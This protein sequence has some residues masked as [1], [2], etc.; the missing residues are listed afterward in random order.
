MYEKIEADYSYTENRELSWL[1]FNL[2]VLEEANCETTPAFERLKFISIFTSNL[3]EFYMVRVGSLYDLATADDDEPDNKSGLTCKEQLEA[4]YEKSVKLYEKKDKAYNQVA[5]ALAQHHICRPSFDELTLSEKKYIDKYFK[6]SILPLL[7]PQVVDNMHPFPHLVNKQPYVAAVLR[8]GKNKCYGLIPVFPAL[9][10]VIVLPE[11]ELRFMLME[12]VI[13]HYAET[14]FEL[15]DVLE[16]TVVCVTRNADIDTDEGLYDADLDFRQHMKTILKKRARLAPVRLETAAPLSEGFRGF[17]C[18][19]LSLR[20]VQVFVSRSPLNM[21]Y[22]FSLED[23]L[24]SS[25][26]QLLLNTPFQPQDSPDVHLRQSLIRQALKKDIL[27]SYPFESMKPFLNLIREAASDPAVLSIKITL[28]RISRESKLAEYLIEAAENGKEITVL[29]ELRARFDEQNNIEWAQRLEEAGC[30]VIYG[31]DGYKVHSKICLIMRKDRSR[32]QYITQIGTGNYNEKT[33]RLYTDLSL[34]TADPAICEDAVNFFKN[35]ALSNLEGSYDKLWVAPYSLKSNVIR[36]IDQEIEKAKQGRKARILMKMNSLTDRDVIDKLAE[37]SQNGVPVKLVIRG[38]CCLIPG[39]PGKTENISVLSIVG[40]FLEHSR[41]YCFGVDGEM[42]LYIASADMM[43]RNTQR[44]VEIACP[45]E[46]PRLKERI[47]RM[48]EI[49]FADTVKGRVLHRDGEYRFRKR[50]P[51]DEASQEYFMHEA[52]ER[53][54]NGSSEE[55]RPT[56]A[57]RFRNLFHHS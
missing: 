40:R 57:Q 49:M 20:P 10:R 47:Y 52:I 43:T 23:M 11:S 4:I 13:L 22:V 51:F 34:I 39:I 6:K 26:K 42:E 35:M 29:M 45:V 24:P 5:Q 17:L 44:R 9:G 53:A 54:K 31:F 1:K 46:N 7:S 36:K 8:H 15:Y 50:E 38:I 18:E 12:D 14:I 21:S 19:R 37:A 56:I 55:T 28:Y 3:D 27:L 41:V 48:L 33:S 30:N 16:K 2:R 25:V 32:L